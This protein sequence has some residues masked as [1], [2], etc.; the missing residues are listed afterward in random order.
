MSLMHRWK[1]LDPED[2]AG[3]SHGHLLPAPKQAPPVP[4][5][6]GP[7]GWVAEF[8][9]WCNTSPG[10]PPDMADWPSAKQ[11]AWQ[12]LEAIRMGPDR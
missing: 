12:D 6:D 2:F 4:V 8:D 1:K 5:R 10:S 9:A 11:E 3:S 7:R